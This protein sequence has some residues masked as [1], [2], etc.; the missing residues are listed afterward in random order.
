MMH[1]F[2]P[3]ESLPAG[4]SPPEPGFFV[5]AAGAI[6]RHGVPIVMPERYDTVLYEGELVIVIGGRASRVSEDEAAACILGYTCGMDGSPLV[7]DPAGERDPARSIFG[8][9][10][11]GIAP[12]GPVLIRELDP[13][14]HEI[15]LRVNGEEIERANTRDLIWSPSRIV[16]ELSQR[17]ALEPGDLIFAGARRAVPRMQPGDTI[18][19]EISGI[20][21][22]RTT[23]IGAR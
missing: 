18:E 9:S 6:G 19:V 14:G 23:V 11:D 20:G 21:V 22:L 17:V 1:N 8:K 15:L 10:A 13:A 2:P 7:V 5:R 3:V 12:V 16:S 4:E